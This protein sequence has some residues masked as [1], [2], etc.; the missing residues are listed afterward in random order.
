MRSLIRKTPPPSKPNAICYH[1]ERRLFAH[2]DC[3]LPEPFD[4]IAFEH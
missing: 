1:P 3:E 2:G 4:E